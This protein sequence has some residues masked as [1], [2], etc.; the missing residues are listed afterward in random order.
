MTPRRMFCKLLFLFACTA[1]A[2]GQN[3]TPTP[4]TNTIPLTVPSGT[5]LQI[6]LDKEVRV[7]KVG[8]AIDGRLVQPVY[9]FD[10]LVIPVGTKVT[11]K[12]SKVD[13]V[14][15]WKRTLGILNVDFTPARQIAVEFDDLLLPDGKHLRLK[16]TV[17]PGFG[18]VVRLV[19]AGAHDKKKTAKDAA[20]QQMEEAKQQWQSAMKWVKEP[21]KMH[22]MMR[23]GVAQLPVHP[24]YMD[25]GTLYF[26]ELKQPLGFGVEPVTTKTSSMIGTPPPP[27]SLVHALLITPLNSAAT[28]KGARVEAGLSQPLID[29]DHHLIL[30]QGSRLIGSV[31]QVQPARHLKHNGQLRIVFRELALPDGTVQR[32]DTSLAGIQA[33]DADHARL[34]TEGGAHASSS[35]TRYISTTVSVGLALI[36]S[37]GRRDVGESGPV[38]GGATSFKLVGIL[39]GLIVRSHTLGIVMSAYGG[40]R[41][42]YTNFFGRG[43]DIAFPKNTAMLIGFGDRT[44]PQKPMAP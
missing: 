41:S 43:R 28:Q 33:G 42:I 36:G 35:K 12:I 29:G 30:P 37:G 17:T 40:S 31:L 1:M 38:A 32:V 7:R 3:G 22:W 10:R 9:A 25:A 8:Q 6:A 34:D 18:Q 27:G 39:V 20:S 15:A 26:A 19:S 44:A 11:G 16:T 14:S 4:A 23:Y 13:S 21:G 2:Y 5:P 24:Q